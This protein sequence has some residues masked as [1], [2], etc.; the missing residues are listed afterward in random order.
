MKMKKSI[1][2]NYYFVAKNKKDRDYCKTIN[3]VTNIVG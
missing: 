3:L 2:K 1:M